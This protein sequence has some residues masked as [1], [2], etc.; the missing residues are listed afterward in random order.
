M[1]SATRQ[2]LQR[3]QYVSSLVVPKGPMAVASVLFQ[4]ISIV[5]GWFSISVEVFV[6]RPGSFGERYLS[7]LRLYMA[8]FIMG[9]FTFFY[10][11]IHVLMGG[12]SPLSFLGYSGGL[13]SLFTTGVS[14][15]LY[16]LYFYG[17]LGLAAWHR[18]QIWRRNQ[19]QVQW[20]TMSFGISW[21]AG[22]PWHRLQAIPVIGPYLHVDDFT[23]FRFIEPLC[24]Y[25]AGRLIWH[26]DGL[27]GWWLII[28]SV[29][30]FLRNNMAYFELRG[31]VL[32]LMD[33]T[34][35]STYLSAALT[36]GPK[37][38]TAGFA[39]VPMPIEGV[40]EN[41]TLDLGATVRDTMSMSIVP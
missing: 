11:L 41:S 26:A 35:E 12:I 14:S 19:E 27:L 3:I 24:C 6:R 23:L 29:A 40:L 13:S 34:I 22:L 4:A 10:T 2:E 9:A 33:A 7:W 16:H 28:A 36:G 20:H 39:V 32:D 1:D 17:F 5:L 37:E 38:Q 15:L 30:L 18:Y 31:R 8:Y 21:L 25:I